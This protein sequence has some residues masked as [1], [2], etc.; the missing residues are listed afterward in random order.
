MRRAARCSSLG[1]IESKRGNILCF[2]PFDFWIASGD[3]SLFSS[4][5]FVCVWFVSFSKSHQTATLNALQEKKHTAADTQLSGRNV[6]IIKYILKRE[7]ERQTN[8]NELSV[9]NSPLRLRLL[10]L[11]LALF[12]LAGIFVDVVV[13]FRR[14]IGCGWRQRMGSV[15]SIS[16]YDRAAATCART[17]E[18]QIKYLI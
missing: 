14:R 4:F 1:V 2:S 8:R 9:Q 11:L 13:A 16:A 5:Y 12:L 10:L 18:G 6:S 7:R 3:R 15:G 17:K